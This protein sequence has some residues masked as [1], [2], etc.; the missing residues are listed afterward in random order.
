MKRIIMFSFIFIT[1]LINT[2]EINADEIINND[3]I[4]EE[5]IQAEEIDFNKTGLIVTLSAFNYFSIGVG[6]NIGEWFRAGHHFGGH[7][8]GILMEY[9]TIDELHIRAY[10][11]IY[12]GSS[13]IYLGGSAIISTNFE[14]I[15]GGVAPEIGIGVPGFSLFY[16][17]NLYFHN[18]SKFNCH[19]IVMQ[20]YGF[21]LLKKNRK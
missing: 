7:N 18:W 5:T 21:R 4:I 19:E 16:R 2:F 3:E 10:G 17:Y 15:T 9:K 11:N 12:G 13:A 20:M 14:E 8:Y 6:W 1:I